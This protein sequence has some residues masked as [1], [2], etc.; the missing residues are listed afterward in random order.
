MSRLVVGALDLADALHNVAPHAEHD[1]RLGMPVL[2]HLLL[3]VDVDNDRLLVV[4]TDRYTLAEQ[5]V[6]LRPDASTTDAG[7]RVLLHVPE[8][9]PL[10]RALV[11][12]AGRD[13][14]RTAA[15]DLE[16]RQ[17]TIGAS[18]LA[19][20]GMQDGE[21]PRYRTLFPDADAKGKGHAVVGVGAQHIAK[22][23]DLWL[24]GRKTGV[25]DLLRL[26]T[27]T[28][29]TKPI[30]VAPI[31]LLD[32]GVHFRSLLMPVRLEAAA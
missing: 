25:V 21:F 28:T 31:G 12:Y 11:K 19:L 22:Y 16:Q 15:V 9:K 6:P 5:G 27:G 23:A 8:V 3:D 1:S 4:G 18:T 10:T 14:T 2:Q 24:H 29:P 30:G 26:T 7:A 32:R 20:D 13:E 17:L